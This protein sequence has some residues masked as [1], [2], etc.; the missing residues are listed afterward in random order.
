[1]HLHSDTQILQLDCLADQRRLVRHH[2][3]LANCVMVWQ[4]YHRDIKSW[5]VCARALA[6]TFSGSCHKVPLPVAEPGL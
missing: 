4:L 3:Q 5:Q 6:T 2:H 1:M